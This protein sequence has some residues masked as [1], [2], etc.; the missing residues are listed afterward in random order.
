M[1]VTSVRS[2][3]PPS[4]AV[5][6]HS[7]LTKAA[8]MREANKHGSRGL[9]SARFAFSFVPVR[10]PAAV[11]QSTTRQTVFWQ[12]FVC[13][14]AVVVLLANVSPAY[15]QPSNAKAVTVTADRIGDFV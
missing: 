6:T 3:H 10:P 15:A 11:W 9:H 14:S 7:G 5:P 2:Q 4:S 1:V 12:L 13:S 8:D